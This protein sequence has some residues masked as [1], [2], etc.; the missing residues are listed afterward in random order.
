MSGISLIDNAHEIYSASLC[1]SSWHLCFAV[2]RSSFSARGFQGPQGK[3]EALNP[4]ATPTLSS[5]LSSLTVGPKSLHPHPTEI[6]GG[7]VPLPN[8]PL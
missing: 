1:F 3:L 7:Q 8:F 4:L 6:A 5:P 2:F